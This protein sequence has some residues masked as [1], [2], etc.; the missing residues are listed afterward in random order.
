[1]WPEQQY[2]QMWPQQFYQEAPLHHSLQIN[3]LR[4]GIEQLKQQIDMLK[5]E[6]Q[7]AQKKMNALKKEFERLGCDSR[8]MHF[9]TARKV[10]L[11]SERV[12]YVRNKFTKSPQMF[13]MVPVYAYSM[14]PVNTHQPY[15]NVTPEN[16]RVQPLQMQMK[17][18]DLN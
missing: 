5:N 3:E 11:L 2:E 7:E 1:M 17:I 15:Q 14:Y 4:N 9:S 6:H 18:E 10:D 12:D 13:Y 8:S 16:S